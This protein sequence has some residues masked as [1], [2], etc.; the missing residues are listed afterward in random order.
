METTEN[1][2]FV[3]EFGNFVLDPNEKTLSA[4]GVAIHLPAKEFDTLLLLIEHNGHALSKSAMMSAIWHDAFVEESNLAKQISRLRKIFNTNGNK[5]IETVPKHG[6]RFSADLRRVATADSELP[7]IAERR[8]KERVTLEVLND[9]NESADQKFLPPAPSFSGPLQKLLITVA[10]A[11]LGFTLLLL[12]QKWNEP[13]QKVTSIAVLPFEQI[14]GRNGDDNLRFGLT[15][16]LITKIGSL[17]EIITRPTNAVRRFDGK[18]ALVAGRE[19]GVDAV[20]EGKVQHIDDQIRVTVQLVTVIDGAIVWSGSFNEK[21]TDLFGVQDAISEQVARKLVPGLTGDERSRLAKRS[22]K[23][24]EAHHAYVMGRYLWNKR[25]GSDIRES[26]KYFDDAID[27]DPTYALAYAGLADAYSLLADYNFATP[28]DS[29]TKARSA[30]EKALEIDGELAEAHTSLAYV[31]MYYFWNWQAADD[32]YKKAIELN[33]NYATAHQWYSEYLAG[34]SR[35]DE[36]LTEIRR[37][38]EIDPLSPVINAGEVW[39]LYWSRRYDEAIEKGRRLAEQ[40]PN[41]AE[42]NEYLKRSY[43][44]K[45]MYAEAIACRQTRR[46]LVGID[47]TMTPALE[48]AAAAKTAAEYWAAR[49]EQELAETRTEGAETFDLAEI[50]SQ[51]GDRDMAF[52]WLE[53]AIDERT[54]TVMYLKVAPNFDLIRDDPR[55]QNLLKKVNLPK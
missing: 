20:L 10:V 9:A 26:I 37:A 2:A 41:F 8:V 16:A 51:L 18:D 35:F 52:Y 11:A 14:A 34:M 33:P 32:D 23:N 38:E 25:T 54:Y 7:V 28:E 53:K 21:F 24:V 55:F 13:T 22:T 43:D 40:N 5:F 39:V 6:Y 1:K 4:D 3:Y 42:V 45:G 29:Y 50:Y 44:Q 36:A 49:L 12:W 48:R 30:A 47:P 19:L 17:R 15:D 27:K 46:K 31:N